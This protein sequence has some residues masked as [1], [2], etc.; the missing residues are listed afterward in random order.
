LPV[1]VTVVLDEDAHT[2]QV[3]AAPANTTILVRVQVISTAG[4]AA[5]PLDE[6]EAT[7]TVTGGS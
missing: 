4:G 7:A 2:I 6:A 5:N 1:D 3:T